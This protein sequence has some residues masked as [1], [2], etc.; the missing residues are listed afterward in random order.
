MT[1]ESLRS[2]YRVVDNP[3][4]AELA[5][6]EWCKQALSLDSAYLK[7]IVKCLR[8]HWNGVLGFWKYDSL[9]SSGMEGFNNKVRT[10]IRQAYGFRDDEYMQLKIFDLPNRRV[11]DGI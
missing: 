9:T 2:I 7:K 1:K 6:D 8:R 11:N 5:L 3:L 10:M 4:E